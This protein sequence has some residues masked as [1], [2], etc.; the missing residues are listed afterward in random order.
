MRFLPRRYI[1]VGL[2]TFVLTVVAG[3]GVRWIGQ[4]NSSPFVA[5]GNRP[6]EAQTANAESTL[7]QDS[8]QKLDDRL[9]ESISLANDSRYADAL[10]KLS[11]IPDTDQAAGQANLLRETWSLQMLDRA[12]EKYTQADL[13]G[14]IAIATAIPQ[15]TEAGQEAKKQI[16]TWRRQKLIIDDALALLKSNPQQ[17][18]DRISVLKNAPFAKSNRYKRWVAQAQ[19]QIRWRQRYYY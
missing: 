6:V 18:L 2:I 7:I 10:A 5:F 9:K 17:A 16:P 8:P 15:E 13:K 14:A 12:L 11:T 1:L 3:V 19:A 4:N